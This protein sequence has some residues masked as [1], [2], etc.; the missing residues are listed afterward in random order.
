[1][2]PVPV[3]LS[4]GMKALKSQK[5]SYF[6]YLT[7][8]RD[9]VPSR[10]LSMRKIKEVLR[11]RCELKLGYQQIGRSCAIAASTVGGIER[12]NAVAVLMLMAK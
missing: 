10:R 2:I 4:W 3:R 6:S 8:G 5:A 1:M 11:L 9:R 12:P 7:Y